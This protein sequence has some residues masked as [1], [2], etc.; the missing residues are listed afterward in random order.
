LERSAIVTNIHVVRDIVSG[1]FFV[2]EMN[3][4][5]EILFGKKLEFTFQKYSESWLPHPDNKVDLCILL[6]NS[7]IDEFMTKN[8]RPCI[9]RD[10][11]ETIPSPEN[12]SL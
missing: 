2:N 4:Q 5:K 10:I 1:H 7:Q 12:G 11:C 6:F 8:K 3:K 9:I